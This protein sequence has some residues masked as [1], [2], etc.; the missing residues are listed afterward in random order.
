MVKGTPPLELSPVA[1]TKK[2]T[3]AP[4]TA[5][6]APTLSGTRQ[7]ANIFKLQPVI[8][9]LGKP[10]MHVPTALTGSPTGSSRRF[11]DPG[12][13]CF[14]PVQGL[15]GAVG[16]PPTLLSLQHRLVVSGD[17]VDLS[18]PGTYQI[19]YNC[20]NVDGTDAPTQTRTI[21]VRDATTAP[22]RAPTRAPTPMWYARYARKKHR[23]HFVPTPEPTT[24]VHDKTGGTRYTCHAN[25]FW[26]TA[27]GKSNTARKRTQAPPV[28]AEE[29]RLT[30]AVKTGAVAGLERRC[31]KLGQSA[32]HTKTA[33]TEAGATLP[34][35]QAV[36]S[37]PTGFHQTWAVNAPAT[38]LYCESTP[39]RKAEAEQQGGHFCHRF[40]ELY[41]GYTCELC[42]KGQ[43]TK[44]PPRTCNCSFGTGVR[45]CSCRYEQ[46]TPNVCEPMHE[47]SHVTCQYFDRKHTLC[48]PQHME[49]I[50]PGV[51][52]VNMKFPKVCRE[53]TTTHMIVHHNSNDW[54]G[55]AETK[56]PNGHRCGLNEAG[57][58]CECKCL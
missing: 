18:K 45:R 24:F 14:D 49:H 31:N 33:T 57:N 29:M 13:M 32:C 25:P 40:E 9:L 8:H 50:V 6:P 16:G 47:C 54:L 42:P 12:A 51:G 39:P 20:Q 43:Y 48:M 5:A 34:Q 56:A 35:C 11:S 28:S 30:E 1:A 3:P 44:R 26:A 53:V 7:H 46:T 36:L 52:W 22:T 37:C 19:R 21:V 23:W 55:V 4:R 41:T 58:K 10:T 2:P 27:E 38:R 17:V 15:Q